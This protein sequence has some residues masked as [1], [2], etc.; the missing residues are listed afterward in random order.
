MAA[1]CVGRR[2][3]RVLEPLRDPR[4]FEWREEERDRTDG[5]HSR[6]RQPNMRELLR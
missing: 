3:R 6:R 5:R 4:H 1:G 2:L